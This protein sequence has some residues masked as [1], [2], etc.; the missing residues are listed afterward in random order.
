MINLKIGLFTQKINAVFWQA[1]LIFS[2]HIFEAETHERDEIALYV[3]A[4]IKSFAFEK[5]IAVSLFSQRMTCEVIT[6]LYHDNNTRLI[7]VKFF[8]TFQHG[9]TALHEAAW[10]GF[11]QT[12]QILCKW[13]ANAYIKNRGGFAP[14]HLCCQNGHNETCRVLLL[15]GCKPDIKNNVRQIQILNGVTTKKSDIFY[16]F[17]FLIHLIQLQLKVENRLLLSLTSSSTFDFNILNFPTSNA[18]KIEYGN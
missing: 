9:N 6:I 11:S 5:K 18:I 12:V 16:F 13:K 8:H 3:I 2:N 1:K 17:F 14:L 7:F 4:R 15:A 10:K